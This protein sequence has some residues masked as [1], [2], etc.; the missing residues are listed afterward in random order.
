MKP[1]TAKETAI[2]CVAAVAAIALLTIPFEVEPGGQAPNTRGL[3]WLVVAGVIAL[4]M[5]LG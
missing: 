1:G 4:G 5:V 2:I 3:V